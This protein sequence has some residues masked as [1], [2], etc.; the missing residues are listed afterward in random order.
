MKKTLVNLAKKNEFIRSILRKILLIKRSFE[1]NIFMFNKVDD[2][3]LIFESFMGKMYT[4]SPKAIYEYMQ[5]D[6]KYADYKYVWAFKDVAAKEPLFKNFKNTTLVKYR[7]K[8]YYKQYNQAKYFVSNSRIPDEIRKKKNQIY[9]QTW[10]GTP[11]KRLGFD[12]DFDKQNALNSIKDIRYKYESDAIRYDYM[13]SPSKFCTEKLTSAFNLKALKKD[14]IIIEKGYPRNDRLFKSNEQEVFELKQRFNIPINKKVILYAPTWRD[15]QHETGI[16][17]TYSLGIDFDKFKSTLSD[18][19]VIIFRTHYFV[20]NSFDFDKYKGF[21]Y[22]LSEHDDINDLYL[23]SDLLITDY[24]SVFFDFANLKRPMLFYMY[25]LEHYKTKLR[26]FYFGLEE[27]PGPIIEKEEDLINEIK[28][29]NTYFNQYKEKYT[30]FN[31]KFNYLD[32][33]EST[34]KVVEIIIGNGEKHE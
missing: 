6:P 8:E 20:S 23:I 17:Y 7:S 11:L 31:N 26:D 19:Y 33:S 1:Y 3:T 2:K 16:G 9:V 13:I 4:D 24:S 34:K 28:N 22:N 27:L 30:K 21:I 18:Q 10:H 25:D 12:L 32:S 29:I 5:N 14:H 15:N